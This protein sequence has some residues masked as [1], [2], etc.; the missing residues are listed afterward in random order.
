VHDA[1][2]DEEQIK[3]R[4]RR[5]SRNGAASVA[6][7][8]CNGESVVS[9][10]TAIGPRNGASGRCLAQRVRE[11]IVTAAPAERSAGLRFRNTLCGGAGGEKRDQ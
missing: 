5:P 10:V 9:A 4:G 11:H 1:G 7:T 2:K 8:G 6:E 3:A